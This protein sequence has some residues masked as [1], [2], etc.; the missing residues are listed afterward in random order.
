MVKENQLQGG[1]FPAQNLGWVGRRVRVEWP[2]NCSIT[3]RVKEIKLP[4]EQE[5]KMAPRLKYI[6]VDTAGVNYQIFHNTKCT[7]LD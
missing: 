6:C 4:K 1:I 2:S 7:L 5:K 3:F